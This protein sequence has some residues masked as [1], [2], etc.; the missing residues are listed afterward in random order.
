MSSKFSDIL[1]AD[2]ID[3][4]HIDYDDILQLYK[5]WKK[6]ES[7]LKEKTKQLQSVHDKVKSLQDSHFEFRSQIQALESVKELTL[8]LQ[9][10]VNGLKADNDK[11]VIEN[12]ELMELNA[13]AEV[14]LRQKLQSES[15]QSKELQDCRRELESV[16]SKYDQLLKSHQEVDIVAADEQIARLTIEKKLEMAN[17]TIELIKEDHRVLRNKYEVTSSRLMQ[18]DKELAHASEQLGILSQEI[19]NIQT[20][21]DKL[22]ISEAEVSVLKADIARLVHLLEFY[23]PLRG[24]MKRWYDSEGMTFMG[25]SGD[26]YQDDNG[27][28]QSAINYLSGLYSSLPSEGRFG[29]QGEEDVDYDDDEEDIENNILNIN[30]YVTP[31]EYE[32][33][34]HVHNNDPYPI[35]AAEVSLVGPSVM[36]DFQFLMLN[37]IG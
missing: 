13:Q 35:I 26:I 11:L 36:S 21:N 22:S 32:H 27:R 19:A 24:F 25:L 37:G 7:D 23:P 20:T 28:D 5:G 10:E 9:N 34:K 17:R 1:K 2:A 6:S 18:C 15:Q 31:T 12:K 4:E 8:T 3:M 29:N 33:T 30:D 14:I 16:R